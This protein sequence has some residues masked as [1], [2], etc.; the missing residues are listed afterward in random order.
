MSVRRPWRRLE[1]LE[2]AVQERRLMV[3]ESTREV[4][5]WSL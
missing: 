1:N 2:M 5:A 4:I 3:V